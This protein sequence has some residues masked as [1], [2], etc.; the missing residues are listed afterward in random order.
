MADIRR[1]QSE[2]GRSQSIGGFVTPNL[3][4]LRDELRYNGCAVPE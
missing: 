3:Q 2:Y 1:L 4:S